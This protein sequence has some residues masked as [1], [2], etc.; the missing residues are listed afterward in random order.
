LAVEDVTPAMALAGFELTYDFGDPVGE[1]IACRTDCALFDFS[2]LECA[3][4]TGYRAGEVV[5]T[6]TGRSMSALQ[7]GRI[8]Y[9]LRVLSDG[10][11]MADLTV[12]KTGSNSYEV[13]SGRR[14]DITDLLACSSPEARVVDVTAERTVF[15]VQGPGSLHA[16]R[17][18]GDVSRVGQLPYFAFG[19]ASLAGIPCRLGRLGYTGEAG[20]EIIAGRRHARELWD[21]LSSQVRPAGFVAADILRIEA[22]FV[23]FSNEFRL[24]V[25]PAE[26]G[27]AGFGRLID[28]PP[29]EI[30]LV[31]FLAEADLGTWPWQPSAGLRRPSAPFEIAITSACASVMAGGVLG[32]GYV[33]AGTLPGSPLHDPAGIFRNIRLTSKPFHD[34]GKHRP[35][36]P[37]PGASG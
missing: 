23:L 28:A 18:L 22:G 21:A 29:P 20:F 27:L 35:R 5:E 8:Y 13:M 26:I 24:P 16:L 15:A 30:Q 12:W 10:R 37:W 31:S 36:A 2:F 34:P 33:L 25:F 17:K 3:E 11:V 6:F 7:E 4:I 9:A 1:A 32:L 14:E 19:E